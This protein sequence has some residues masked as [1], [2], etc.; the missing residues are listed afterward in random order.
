MLSFTSEKEY[1]KW[2]AGTPTP[3]ATEKKRS[4]KPKSIKPKKAKPV[5]AECNISTDTVE[6]VF[7]KIHPST[8]QYMRWHWT[9]RNQETQEWAWLMKKALKGQQRPFIEN[10]VIETIYYFS[11]RRE[12]DRGNYIPKFVIDAIVNEGII[13]DDAASILTETMPIFCYGSKDSRIV[14]TIKTREKVG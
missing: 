2:A 3:T 8:N 4:I 1:K 6:F 13:K 12:R 7:N 11:D 10:P 14:V 9:K 5:R